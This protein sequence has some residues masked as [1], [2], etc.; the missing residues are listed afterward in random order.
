[1]KKKNPADKTILLRIDYDY[2]SYQEGFAPSEDYYFQERGFGSDSSGVGW[3]LNYFG[4]N[5]SFL[6]V[7]NIFYDTF[8][9]LILL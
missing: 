2:F 6:M 4:Y 9:S 7:T 3:L 1:M 8:T 5:S